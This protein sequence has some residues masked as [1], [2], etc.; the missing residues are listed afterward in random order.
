MSCFYCE[1]DERLT[2]LMEPLAETAWADIYLFRDQKHRGRVV[3]ALKGHHDEIWELDEAQRNGFFGDVALAAEAVS[4]YAHADK[5]N[6]AIYGDIVS[7]FHV[8]IVPKTRDGLE[9]GGPFT[10]KIP[11]VYLPEEEFREVGKELLKKMDEIAAEK[12]IPAPVHKM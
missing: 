8:H 7:H 6:Y 5:I 4:R 9:W 3:T 12:G 2:A 1:K 11:K 10:D